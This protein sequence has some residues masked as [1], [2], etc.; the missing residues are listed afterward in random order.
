MGLSVVAVLVIVLEIVV[1]LVFVTGG[2]RQ[3]SPITGLDRP[4]GFPGV[5][6]PRFLDSGHMKVVRLLALGTGRLYPP[7]NIPGTHFC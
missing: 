6:A 1:I 2:K 5:E 3:S 7:G 4:T